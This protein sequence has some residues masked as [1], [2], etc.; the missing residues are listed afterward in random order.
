VIEGQRDTTR[1]F[2]LFHAPSGVKIESRLTAGR[3]GHR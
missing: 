2:R 3:E 1:T